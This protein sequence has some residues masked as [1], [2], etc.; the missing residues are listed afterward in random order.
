ME[1]GEALRTFLLADAGIAAAVGVRA[2]PV[3]LPQG[4]TDTTR[5]PAIRYTIISG[6]RVQ[7]S[8]QG[9][10]GLA[11]LRLQIDTV[12]DGFDAAYALAEL[13]RKRIDGYRGLMGSVTV[14]GVFFDNERS[15]FEPETR[16][17]FFSRDY[18]VWFQ[19]ATS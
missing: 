11:G 19:E 16:L 7:A 3:E 17:H 10:A 14:R 6:Q 13:V 5:Y 2:Y 9:A 1:I 12:A 15:A 4:K 8:P 18:F